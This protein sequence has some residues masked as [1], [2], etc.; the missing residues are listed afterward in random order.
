MNETIIHF[1]FAR[2]A[3]RNFDVCEAVFSP[4]CLESRCFEVNGVFNFFYTNL[5]VMNYQQREQEIFGMV[6]MQSH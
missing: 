1:Y 3:S 6:N 2:W 4:E 5:L